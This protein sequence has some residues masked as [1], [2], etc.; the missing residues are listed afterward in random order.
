MRVTILGARRLRK[1]LGRMP[2][3]VEI[4]WRTATQFQARNP[5]THGLPLPRRAAMALALQMMDVVRT[6]AEMTPTTQH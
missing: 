4:Q 5:N 2:T 6:A 3:A 1:E